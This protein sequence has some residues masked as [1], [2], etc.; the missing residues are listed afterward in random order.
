MSAKHG[1]FATTFAL[2]SFASLQTALADVAPTCLDLVRAGVEHRTAALAS[3]DAAERQALATL[4]IADL[5]MSHIACG[6]NGV[7]SAAFTAYWTIAKQQP[8]PAEK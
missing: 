1:I 8:Q 3:K 4:A 5:E 7:Q 6:G 2:L